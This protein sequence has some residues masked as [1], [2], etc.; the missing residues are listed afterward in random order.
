MRVLDHFAPE[1]IKIKAENIRQPWMTSELLAL[2]RAKD[3]MYHKCIGK[4]GPCGYINNPP[5]YMKFGGIVHIPTRANR[6]YFGAT[7]LNI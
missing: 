7:Q 3:K 5:I 4:V 6:L 2:S 1:T